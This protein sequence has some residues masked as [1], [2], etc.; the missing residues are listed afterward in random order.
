[1]YKYVSIFILMFNREKVVFAS[2]VI[3]PSVNEPWLIPNNQ[4]TEWAILEEIINFVP[5]LKLLYHM[6]HEY[7]TT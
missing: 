1:M 5:L 3:L 2:T 7:V 6:Y 4:L